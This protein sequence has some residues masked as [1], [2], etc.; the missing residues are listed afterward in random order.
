[1]LTYLKSHISPLLKGM[2]ERLGKSS[3]PGETFF[4][5]GNYCYPGVDNTPTQQ[6]KGSPSEIDS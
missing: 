6:Q 1:M 2:V 5:T 4:H 3:Q